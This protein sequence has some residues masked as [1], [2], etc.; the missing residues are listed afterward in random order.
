LLA[1]AANTGDLS[2]WNPKADRGVW[3]LVADALNTRTYA[4]GDFT[5]ISGQ[6]REGFAQFSV[7]VP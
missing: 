5:K 1:V 2:A 6:P 4:G 3:V 7:V